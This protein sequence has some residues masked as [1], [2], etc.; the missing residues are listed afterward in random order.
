MKKFV[1][2]ALGLVFLGSFGVGTAS[3]GP[4]SDV[5]GPAGVS[6][7]NVND[8]VLYTKDLDSCKKGRVAI[9]NYV[10]S[11]YDLIKGKNADLILSK[12]RKTALAYRVVG[13]GHD[14]LLWIWVDPI[15]RKIP[16]TADADAKRVAA[17]LI[18]IFES[19]A[20]PIPASCVMGSGVIGPCPLSRPLT[21]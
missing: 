8:Q 21:H 7:I 20:Q 13:S 2:M 4:S 6:C 15:H 10:N 16:D 5:T 19:A 3:A 9:V 18:Y 1:G 14:N 17:E 11:H 12:N